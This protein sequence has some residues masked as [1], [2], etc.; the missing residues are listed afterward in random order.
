M[1]LALMPVA[2]DR[3]RGE[4]GA[5]YHSVL[6][7]GRIWRAVSQPGQARVAA[8]REVKQRELIPQ[9]SA[10]L[11]TPRPLAVSE[12]PGCRRSVQWTVLWVPMSCEL[13][14]RREMGK[15]MG[16][17]MACQTGMLY[18]KLDERPGGKSL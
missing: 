7:L 1:L 6:Q 8:C 11:G 10:E 3:L 17:Q 18:S 2:H 16:E 12:H 15:P 5:G 14:S 4:P 9:L 13:S